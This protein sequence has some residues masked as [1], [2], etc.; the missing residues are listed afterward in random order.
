VQGQCWEP[1]GLRWG[2]EGFL[3]FPYIHSGANTG[4]VDPPSVVVILSRYHDST[5]APID[6]SKDSRTGLYGDNAL[7]M[8]SQHAQ[9]MQVM[10]ME[11]E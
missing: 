5:S 10:T 1:H 6:G 7:A 8:H 11:R 2:K 4:C 3:T 9:C